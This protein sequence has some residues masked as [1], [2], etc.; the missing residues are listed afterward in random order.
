MKKIKQLIK[1]LAR[2]AMPMVHSA[3]RMATG[4]PGIGKVQFGDFRRPRPISRDFGADRGTPIDRF[5]VHAFLERHAADVKGAAL[6]I[7]EDTYTRRYGGAQVTHADILH[8]SD[9][10]PKATIVADLSNAPHI[11]DERFDTVIMTQT[12][13]LIFDFTAA[14]RT[15]HRIL[16]PGGVLL[17]TVPG[18]TPVAAGTRWGSTWLWSFTEISMRRLLAAVFGENNFSLQVNGNVLAAT[19]FLQGLAVEELER[20]E[21]EDFDAS[22]PLIIAARVQKRSAS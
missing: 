7:G 21:L 8:V 2:P 18:I 15:V 16:K 4:T 1:A 9:E 19:A 12:L 14:L 11:Q 22:Y 6:E 5:Y 3:V 17:L 20:Q 10:N 13:H